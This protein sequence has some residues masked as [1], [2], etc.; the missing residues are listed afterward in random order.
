[1]KDAR[2][3]FS[4]GEYQIGIK[5]LGEVIRTNHKGEKHQHLANQSA[6]LIVDELG[7]MLTPGG[8]IWDSSF[9]FAETEGFAWV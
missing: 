8:F 7:K 5:K 4:H 6:D 9:L 2:E 1:M 3:H